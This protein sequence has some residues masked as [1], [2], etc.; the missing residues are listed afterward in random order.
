MYL[1]SVPWCSKIESGHVREILIEEERQV[2]GVKFFG[3]GVKPRMSLNITVMSVFLFDELRLT[4][5]LRITSGLNIVRRPSARGVF[6]FLQ[7]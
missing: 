4:S 2:L 3:N 5:S 7:E 1:S 6:P